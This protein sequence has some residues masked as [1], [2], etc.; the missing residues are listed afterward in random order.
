MDF[1]RAGACYIKSFSIGLGL[2]DSRAA[3]SFDILTHC[4]AAEPRVRAV[5]AEGMKRLLCQVLGKHEPIL[6]LSHQQ[7]VIAAAWHF[8]TSP[9]PIP[10][11]AQPASLI[12]LPSVTH[13]L[14]ATPRRVRGGGSHCLDS[15][16]H[17]CVG[18][19][20][21]CRY[22]CRCSRV[23]AAA[24][25]AAA[26]ALTYTSEPIARRPLCKL[27]CAI[28]IPTPGSKSEHLSPEICHQGPRPP[29]RDLFTH[30]CWFS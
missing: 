22:S 8:R 4:P 10:D 29:E 18:V 1:L 19:V 27:S 24:S 28:R 9:W 23:A 26:A 14:C 13:S 16:A 11:P 21:S 7:Y 30:S 15:L 2:F 17:T 5:A 3:P 12:R 6:N 20:C 25:V